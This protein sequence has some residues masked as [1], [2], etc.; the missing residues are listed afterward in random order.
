MSN[1]GN[2]FVIPKQAA[3]PGSDDLLLCEPDGLTPD[4][5][6]T[7]GKQRPMPLPIQDR[8]AVRDKL[9]RKQNS[10]FSLFEVLISITAFCMLLGM[11]SWIS[12]DV[13]ILTLGLAALTVLSATTFFRL[14]RVALIIFCQVL[15]VYFGTLLIALI[16]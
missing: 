13:Y 12:V 16:G 8:K 1:S 5:V 7:G 6:L 4:Q 9:K 2:D 14:R 10:Q 15:V 3:G 11:Y